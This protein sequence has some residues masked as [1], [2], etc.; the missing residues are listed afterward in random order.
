MSSRAD[1]PETVAVSVRRD[2]AFQ[3]RVAYRLPRP[4]SLEELDEVVEGEVELQAFS[5]QIQGA[6]DVFRFRLSDAS[7][8]T[9]VVGGDELIVTYGKLGRAAV[10]VDRPEMEAFLEAQY[11]GLEAA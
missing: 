6:R 4:V 3:L 8:V 1:P 5:Q 11:G 9:G 7:L 10:T 2:C